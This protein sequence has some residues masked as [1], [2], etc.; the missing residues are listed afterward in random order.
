M[1]FTRPEPTFDPVKFPKVPIADAEGAFLD[2]Y[3]LLPGQGQAV[4]THADAEKLYYVLQ[5]RGR[6]TL[7]GDVRELGP[8][9]AAFAPRGVPHG[10]ENASAD[11]LVT[12]TVLTPKPRH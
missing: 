5:G 10:V 1:A 12:L 2:L 8:G 7:G 11:P 6:F 9:E 4:H 3:C